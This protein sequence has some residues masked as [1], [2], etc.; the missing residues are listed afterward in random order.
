[1]NNDTPEEQK[2]EKTP[3]VPRD[4]DVDNSSRK[5]ETSPASAADANIEDEEYTDRDKPLVADSDAA[6]ALHDN[7]SR[8][9]GDLGVGTAG[10]AARP[11][12]T[13][14]YGKPVPPRSRS[15]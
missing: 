5:R 7:P 9:K 6:R 10:D 4:R 8:T 12:K 11:S 13:G 14:I 1:M 3:T 2:Q 15:Q